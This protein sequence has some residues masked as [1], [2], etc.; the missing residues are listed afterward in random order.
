MTG[1]R[2]RE[3]IEIRTTKKQLIH[4]TDL[5]TQK[6]KIIKIHRKNT[7]FQSKFEITR[8]N[9]F[10]SASCTNYLVKISLGKSS[11]K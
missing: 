7:Q 5:L 4:P 3:I 2:S 10:I 8:L 11:K 1:R 6:H 9:S